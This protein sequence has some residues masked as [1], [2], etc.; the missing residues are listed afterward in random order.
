MST[1]HQPQPEL[2]EQS[3]A[4]TK[5]YRLIQ[6]R[7]GHRYSVD[8]MLVAQL[9][10]SFVE[11][12]KQ[13][14]PAHVLDLGCGLGSVLLIMAWAW[15]ETRF[16]GLEALDEHVAYARR[17]ILLN[18]CEMRAQ[19]IAGDMRDKPLLGKLGKFDL[20][21][22]SPPYFTKNSGT[23]CADPARAAAHFELRGG[24]EDYAAAASLCMSDDGFFACCAAAEATAPMIPNGR[25]E[26][27]FIQAGLTLVY[28]RQVI[29]RE[30]KPPFL[31]L[32]VGQKTAEPLHSCKE[33]HALVLRQ[34]DGQRGAEHRQIRQ[35]TGLA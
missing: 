12:H 17:N 7:R 9:A 5:D 18:S 28:R 35:W 32:L 15:A 26:A 20:V 19:I 6:K 31:Q 8:D 4:L 29:P 2:H 21:T 22:G 27:A 16:V 11:K 33:A 23:L 13:P 14:T 24:I 25:A 1:S 34:R 30:G 10:V 3:I